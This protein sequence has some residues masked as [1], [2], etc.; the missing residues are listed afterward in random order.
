M[1]PVCKDASLISQPLLENRK[2]FHSN[3]V[4][5]FN[6]YTD[7][8]KWKSGEGGRKHSWEMSLTGQLCPSC[9]KKPCFSM[10]SQ[11]P[12]KFPKPRLSLARNCISFTSATAI[13]P[14]LSQQ[15]RLTYLCNSGG[16]FVL[17]VFWVI[18]RFWFIDWINYCALPG[19]PS[20]ASSLKVPGKIKV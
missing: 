17:H 2:Q 12:V 4:Q 6:I 14:L 3:Y 5:D 18:K 8:K 10:G 19:L 9:L 13:L 16:G 15:H 1:P 7:S 11:L 20:G